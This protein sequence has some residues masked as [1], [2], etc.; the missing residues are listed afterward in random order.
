M[1]YTKFQVQSLVAKLEAQ[2]R[3]RHKHQGTI[4]I[5]AGENRDQKL[6]AAQA[7]CERYGC[8]YGYFV[9]EEAI[10]KGDWAIA[11]TLE[12]A[13]HRGVA[14]VC[15]TCHYPVANGADGCLV[16]STN[17][18]RRE[19]GEALIPRRDEEATP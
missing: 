6:A 7:E 4:R 2:D 8:T 12:E 18:E 19:R 17:D 10:S 15:S 11:I 5:R 1:R 16:C 13:D 14:R 9:V 3:P